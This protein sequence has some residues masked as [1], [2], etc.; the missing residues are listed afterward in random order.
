M[1]LDLLLMC[2]VRASNRLNRQPQIH[3]WGEWELYAG[4]IKIS[5]K[6]ALP[7][8]ALGGSLI[9]GGITEGF[10][11]ETLVKVDIKYSAMCVHDDKYL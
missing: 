2:L 9:R 5:K 1:S 4:P 8:S 3:L 6:K 7:F 10:V 11:G